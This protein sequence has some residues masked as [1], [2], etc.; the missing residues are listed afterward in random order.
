MK[1]VTKKLFGKEGLFVL[2]LLVLGVINTSFSTCCWYMLH[3]PEV[4]KQLTG[5]IDLT[6]N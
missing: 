1:K 6:S 3:Q 2:N 5:R 4:P